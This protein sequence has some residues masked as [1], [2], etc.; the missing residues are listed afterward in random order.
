MAIVHTP[1][2]KL[3]APWV[4]CLTMYALLLVMAM[5]CTIQP[6]WCTTNLYGVRHNL[7]HEASVHRGMNHACTIMS[8][9]WCK[10]YTAPSESGRTQRFV[11]HVCFLCSIIIISFL[12]FLRP[13]SRRQC[14]VSF[15][16]DRTCEVTKKAE[17]TWKSLTSH[18]PLL[19]DVAQTVSRP[20][21]TVTTTRICKRRD[22]Q[23]YVQDMTTIIG[24]GSRRTR[25]AEM[26][27]TQHA[28]PHDDIIINNSNL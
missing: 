8:H 3:F 22:K 19:L 24:N 5:A 14:C 21:E 4:M 2:R 26:R 23:L 15:D 9:E 17:F 12:F 28:R 25:T 11:G 18:Q 27:K 16:C 7:R 20:R 1:W 13:L 10:P 6:L